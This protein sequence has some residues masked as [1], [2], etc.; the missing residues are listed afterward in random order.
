M[1][2]HQTPT[3]RGLIPSPLGLLPQLS[4]QIE[5]TPSPIPQSSA[6]PGPH[7]RKQHDMSLHSVS[8]ADWHAARPLSRSPCR[9]SPSVPR[10]LCPSPFLLRHFPTLP[11]SRS[12]SRFSSSFC[13]CVSLS[14]SLCLS[15]SVSPS[16]THTHTHTHSRTCTQANKQSR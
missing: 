12:H 5:K 14:L 4:A 7:R 16:H 1:H 13:I 10:S 2:P 9:L 3:N 11:L 8:R 6:L 15:L